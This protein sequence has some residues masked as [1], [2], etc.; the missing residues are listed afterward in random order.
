MPIRPLPKTPVQ[1]R[2]FSYAEASKILNRCPVSLWRDI[3]AGRL[4]C[5]HIGGSVR[6]TGESIDRIC[7]GK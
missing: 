1:Q 2:L 7:A 6:I 5:V 4:D 3:K